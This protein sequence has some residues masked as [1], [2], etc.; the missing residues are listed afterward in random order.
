MDFI[1]EIQLK[2]QETQRLGL[3]R[4]TSISKYFKKDYSSNN[5]L[6]IAGSFRYKLWLLYAFLFHGTAKCSS[7]Y[8]N[9]YS[10]LHNTLENEITK[11]YN[12]EKAVI[13]SS[14]YLASIGVLQS[15]ATKNT[16]IIA[17]KHIHASWIDGS[18][19]TST[20]IIRFH[21]NDISNLEELLF[22][23]NDKR[24]IIITESVFSMQGTVIDIKKYE[25]LAAKYNAILIVDN[26]HGLGVL[27]CYHIQYPLHIQV[28]TFSK[29]CGGF[30][31]YACG[32]S[33]LMDAVSNF[34]RTQ[35]YS[36]TIP[37]YIL[38]INLFGLRVAKKQIAKGTLIK[39]AKT[40]AK[41]YDMVFKGSAILTKEFKTIEEAYFF[42]KSL[43]EKD[44]YVPV[45]RPP[46]VPKPIVRLSVN[47]KT[48]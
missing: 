26:A 37:E 16:I 29:A 10:K 8:I 28:G 1:H 24:I 48:R 21:H 33:I 7:K 11:S 39:K 12:A 47:L 40:L 2:L 13:F 17:D 31:G 30:G 23:H 43:M 38:I 34:A 25:I 46:T 44:I 9:G 32:N 3:A 27:P 20:R 15:L 35:I 18:F 36:T 22:K 45:I 42:Q 19:T 4:S 41:K 5:Y 14:G 6:G